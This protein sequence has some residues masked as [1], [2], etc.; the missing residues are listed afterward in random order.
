[1]TCKRNHRFTLLPVSLIATQ[2]SLL[3]TW[4]YKAIC[5]NLP[6]AIFGFRVVPG[7]MMP[8]PVPNAACLP[9]TQGGRQMLFFLLDVLDLQKNHNPQHPVACWRS[10]ALVCEEASF[11][12]LRTY[13]PAL[14]GFSA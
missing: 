5:R 6:P 14:A 1:M 10:P 8:G 12:A 2:C 9:D 7:A 3:P 4:D 13:S 11:Q